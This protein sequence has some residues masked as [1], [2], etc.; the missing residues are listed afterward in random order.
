MTS[1]V[2]PAIKKFEKGLTPLYAGKWAEA[3]KLFETVV[4]EAELSHLRVRAQALIDACLRR[5][6]SGTSED[7]PYLDALASKNVGNFDKALSI[8]VQHGSEERFVYLSACAQALAGNQDAA[9]ETLS[10]AIELEPTNR[11]RAFHDSDLESL[12][13]RPEF[14]GLFETSE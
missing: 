1:Y 11:V 14:D 6:E 10:R 5:E 13:G 3:R 12:V 7:D 2:D 9:L 4:E 8:A